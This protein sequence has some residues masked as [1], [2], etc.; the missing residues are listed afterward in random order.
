MDHW[1]PA[2]WVYLGSNRSTKAR[3]CCLF[4]NSDGLPDL[5]TFWRRRCPPTLLARSSFRIG[6]GGSDAALHDHQGSESPARRR[7]S[8]RCHQLPELHIQCFVG[9]AVWLV[10]PKRFAGS[11]A[12]GTRALPNR[13]CA[14]NSRCRHRYCAHLLSQGN[15]L[16]CS[17]SIILKEFLWLFISRLQK[18]AP[19]S[20]SLYLNVAR[21]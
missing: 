5:D 6:L 15:G 8:R 21:I 1:L 7:N 11:D 18:Q 13:V 9:A 3:H 20:M 17:P 10:A 2:S 14:L 12:D 19:A 16:R 4:V